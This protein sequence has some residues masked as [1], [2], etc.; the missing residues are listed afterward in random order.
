MIYFLNYY[1]A[2][3]L[4]ITTI[5]CWEALLTWKNK[6]SSNLK[7][8]LPSFIYYSLMLDMLL[9]SSA[10]S[11]S[12][13]MFFCS[14][15][16]AQVL[17]FVLLSSVGFVSFACSCGLL[18][19]LEWKVFSWQKKKKK[20]EDEKERKYSNK[21]E[22]PSLLLLPFNSFLVLLIGGFSYMGGLQFYSKTQS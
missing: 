10:G 19:F 20:L 14:L 7:M 8:K 18:L 22:M 17:F 4:W 11:P 1:K 13:C 21:K 2:S 12:V 9:L 15:W 3:Y 5:H 16:R 6:W